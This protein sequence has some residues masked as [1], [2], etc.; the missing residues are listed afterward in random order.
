MLHVST[1]DILAIIYKSVEFVIIDVIPLYDWQT[2]RFN[3]DGLVILILDSQVQII[4]FKLL[5]L[6]N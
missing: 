1:A 3:V 5:N 6:I 2:I 4:N